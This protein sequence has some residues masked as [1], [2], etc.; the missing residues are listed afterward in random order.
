MTPAQE[1]AYHALLAACEEYIE[2]FDSDEKST[3][4]DIV[5]Q[6]ERI[7]AAICQARRA[8]EAAYAEH[9][10]QLRAER[11]KDVMLFGKELAE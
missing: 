7:R 3:W 11:K 4:V 8:N 6:N 2:W 5:I 10:E 9:Q 1:D